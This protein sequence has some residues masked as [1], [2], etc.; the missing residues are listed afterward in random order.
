M[1]F[2]SFEIEGR[3]TYGLWK[4][5]DQWIQVPAEFQTQYPDLKSVIANHK[6]DELE[7]VT[8]QSGKLVTSAQAHLLPGHTQSRKSFLCGL[9]LQISR[10]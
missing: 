4:D 2:V 7:L 10:G 1:S 5:E 9:E 6:L 8:R 3:Q